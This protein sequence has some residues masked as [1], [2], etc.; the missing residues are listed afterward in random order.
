M[1]T[2]IKADSFCSSN[3]WNLYDGH[4][5]LRG[6]N[7]VFCTAE[8]SQSNYVFGNGTLNPGSTRTVT[9]DTGYTGSPSAIWCDA[10][11]GYWSTA[12]GCS[13][14]D[15]CSGIDCGVESYCVDE[16]APST[17]YTCICNPGYYSNSGTCSGK[18]IIWK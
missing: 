5:G 11:S 14:T 12:S 1:F 3:S 10:D 8:P 16:V 4:F 17:G 2:R 15:G 18:F 7:D 13:D 6:A 9:C